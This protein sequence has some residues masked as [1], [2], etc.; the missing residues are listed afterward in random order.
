MLPSSAELLNI[1]YL[2]KKY[3]ESNAPLYISYPSTSYW[4]D[5]ADAIKYAADCSSVRNPFL[6]FHFPF[7]ENICHYCMCYKVPGMTKEQIKR[8]VGNLADEIELKAAL[9]E[10]A[11][12]DRVTHLHWGGGTPTCL[13]CDDIS[14]VVEAISRHFNMN[15]RKGGSISIEAYPNVKMVTEEKL[16]L[17]R[18]LGFNEI[19]FG[20]QDL[21]ERVQQAIN[22][23]CRFEELATLVETSKRKGFNVHI[24]LC[25]GLPFQELGGFEKTMNMVLSLEPDRVAMLTYVHYPLIYKNQRHIPLASVPN[26]FMRVMLSKLAEDVFASAN[27]KKIGFDHFV[28]HD[29]V[30]YK[31]AIEGTIARDLMGYSVGERKN[32]IGFGSSA[33]SFLNGTYYHNAMDLGNYQKK[34]ECKEIPLD[35][36]NAYTLNRDDVIRNEIIQTEI[37]SRFCVDKKAINDRF[38]I[39]FDE[40]FSGEMDKLVFLEKDGLVS[41][42][43]PLKIVVTALGR[44]FCRH[45]ASVFDRYY[46]KAGGK[47]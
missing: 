26:S 3:D 31:A 22:R 16:S 42:G 14:S 39:T 28:K 15:T 46:R 44:H 33:I 1:E 47:Q 21:D 7:C 5:N 25:Y 27:Y 19:S 18:T 12:Q 32:F 10:S 30:L 38:G 17:L 13:D 40:Y 23:S 2:S 45:I 37:L 36:R 24:D 4:T 34:V 9:R 35:G 11:L 29:N 6:Y 20:V 8:Y 41:L 43:D